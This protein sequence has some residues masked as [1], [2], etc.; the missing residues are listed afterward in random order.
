MAMSTWFALGVLCLLY[1][2][3]AMW[4]VS[5]VFPRTRAVTPRFDPEKQLKGP[6][7]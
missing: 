6:K 4:A 3:F 7:T 1:V 2:A 5:Q